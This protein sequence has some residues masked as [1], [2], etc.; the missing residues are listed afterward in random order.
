MAR[1]RRKRSS[2]LSVVIIELGAL[3][4]IIAI[5]QPGWLNLFSQSSPTAAGRLGPIQSI[6]SLREPASTDV[7]LPPPLALPEFAPPSLGRTSVVR[8]IPYVEAY[9]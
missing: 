8:S 7:V 2:P 6:Q 1:R 4:G 9:R 5:A 3:L